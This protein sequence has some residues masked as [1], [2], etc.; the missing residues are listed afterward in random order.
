MSIFIFIAIGMSIA[1]YIVLRMM[2]TETIIKCV[3]E[4]IAELYQKK[5][6]TPSECAYVA[7]ILLLEADKITLSSKRGQYILKVIYSNS[8]KYLEGPDWATFPIV[9]KLEE[10][11]VTLGV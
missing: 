8:K 2:R 10:S 6:I 3:C 1:A 11:E 5:G 7:S 9:V 4:T